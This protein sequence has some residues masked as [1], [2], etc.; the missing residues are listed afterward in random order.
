[1]RW[2]ALR[3]SKVEILETSA[4]LL[5]CSTIGTRRLHT[6]GFHHW[7]S[8]VLGMPHP[9]ATRIICNLMGQHQLDDKKSKGWPPTLNS[10]NN[11][12]Q[13][14]LHLLSG[15]PLYK[16]SETSSVLCH[17]WG[18]GESSKKS[19]HSAVSS[20]QNPEYTVGIQWYQGSPLLAVLWGCLVPNGMGAT[21]NIL[22]CVGVFQNKMGSVPLI[23]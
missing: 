14:T 21:Q 11:L 2:M 4:L 23:L 15:C 12:Q 19:S 6:V 17:L 20:W 3:Q 22:A 18:K 8:P 10:T 5:P 16:W 9:G 7:R 13:I 1:M